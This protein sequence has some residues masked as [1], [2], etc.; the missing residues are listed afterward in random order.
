MGPVKLVLA[1]VLALLVG[2]RTAP[3]REEQSRTPQ[4]T[5]SAADTIS[6]RRALSDDTCGLGDFP[7][8]KSTEEI[9]AA[10]P[11]D[12]G[13]PPN[14]MMIAKIAVSPEGRI[15]HLRITRLAWPKLPN[16]EAIN[17][18]A[19]D[20]IKRRHYSPTFIDGRPVAV[21]SDVSVTVDLE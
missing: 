21:C 4:T 6:S 5:F 16:S 1:L 20:S 8:S 12:T 2:C 3:K 11:R 13:Q 17:K 15:T 14:Q 18:Q 19:V 7:V 10:V 9:L